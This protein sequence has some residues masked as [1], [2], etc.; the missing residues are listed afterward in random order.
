MK[1]SKRSRLVISGLMLLAV[2]ALAAGGGV[3][4]GSQGFSPEHGSSAFGPDSVE[5]VTAVSEVTLD[6]DVE[7][8]KIDAGDPVT[9]T[10]TFNNK[11]RSDATVEEIRDTLPAG[12]SFAGIDAASDIQQVP[13][14]ITG[15]IVWNGS[16]EVPARDSLTLIYKA[17]TGGG[18]RDTDK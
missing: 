6:K 2:L 3:A 11:E 5:V 7:P 8:K 17:N 10:V 4:Q 1:R 15:T 9:Y 18:L 13:T 14:G 16:F 12:F